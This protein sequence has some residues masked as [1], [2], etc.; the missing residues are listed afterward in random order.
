MK[1]QF[2]AP[3]VLAGLVL[4]AGCL[5]APLQSTPGASTDG[6]TAPTI[7][8][9]GVGEVTTEADLA[10]IYLSVTATAESADEARG[11]VAEDVASVRQA[12]TDAGISDDNIQTTGFNIWPEYRYGERQELV[13]YRATHTMKVEVAPDQAGEAIDLAV[14]AGSTSTMGDEFTRAIQVQNVQF[15]LTDE[16]RDE[17]RSEALQNA[18]QNARA[19]AD[20][21]AEA[22]NVQIT[23][24]QQ[25]STSNGYTPSPYYQVEYAEDAAARSGGAPTELSPGPVT[26]RA[27][28]NMV[29]TIG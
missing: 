3:L 9:S 19:D 18:V 27:T 6:D 15:T 23:G 21:I 20:S 28:V 7:T 2:I 4:M 13:G 5:S 10:I 14:G 25:A 12:L 16:R 8:T 29:Y 1:R 17:L 24:V 11:M 26:V 22:A